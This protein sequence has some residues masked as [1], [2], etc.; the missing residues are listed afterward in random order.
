MPVAFVEL[1][2][3]INFISLSEKLCI[4][5]T[6]KFYLDLRGKAKDGKGSVVILL[7]NN[8]TTTTIS[9]GVRVLKSEWDGA[10]VINNISSAS[11]NSELS[12]K[13]A[14]IDR[15]IS[16]LA[17]EDGFNNLSA[18]QIKA[19]LFEKTITRKS[20]RVSDV[21]DEYIRNKTLQPGTIDIYNLALKKVVSF[22]GNGFHIEDINLK[23]LHTFDKYLSQT[24]GV[25]GR[26]MYMRC[27]RAI[28]RY[29]WKTK[30][31]S[32]YPF[33]GFSIKQEPT[34]KRCISVEQL[35]EL[36]N[37]P[38]NTRQQVFRDYF[39]LM[40]Y[41]IGINAVDLL[42]A[43]KSA[44]VNG[45][46]EYIR[47]KTHKPYSIKIE[48]EAEVLLRKYAG[49]KYLLE[50]M[51]RFSSH[52]TFI[53]QM[54]DSLQSIGRLTWE[55]IPDPED[56]FAMPRLEKHIEPVIPDITTYYARHTWST[57]AY[58]AGVPIDIV[59]QAM[60]HSMGNRTTMIYVKLDPK[61]VDDAN[62]KVIDYLFKSGH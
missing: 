40:F 25:N 12:L 54:D 48:P 38:V 49:K 6:T 10:R 8:R 33:E 15:K 45:R 36:M 50:G 53:H 55:M 22:A 47:R 59:A 19:R 51:D 21:F 11:L 26:S 35:R 9:T 29:A 58:E 37:Y 17:F 27:I 60:G 32:D 16:V 5:F 23:W 52:K 41:L 43:K 28:C 44:I 31:I 4:M 18:A 1:F 3:D 56:L 42:L 13:K 14:D 62:R 7:C 24:Q 57:L 20:M 61:K 39:F 2:A 46:F 34:P 30:L